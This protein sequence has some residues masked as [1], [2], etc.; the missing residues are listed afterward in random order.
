MMVSHQPSCV[1]LV[2]YL[3][4]EQQLG[5]ILNSFLIGQLTLGFDVVGFLFAGLLLQLR[6]RIPLFCLFY[7]T[8]GFINLLP[9]QSLLCDNCGRSRRLSAALILLF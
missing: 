3:L 9:P 6:D 4:I 5:H 7:A 1:V 2:Y 8:F